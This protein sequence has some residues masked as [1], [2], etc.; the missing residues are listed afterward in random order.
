MSGPNKIPATAAGE[1]MRDRFGAV[2]CDLVISDERVFVLLADISVDRLEPARARF[3]D[4]VV[5]AGIME[6]TVMGAAAGIAIEGFIPVV[7][8]IVPFIVHRPY[9]QIRDGFLYQ[10]VGV[11]IISIG[12]S[13]DYAKEGYTH[14]GPDDVPALHALA[15]MRIALPGTPA[16]F[17]T[18]LRA[19]YD[20]GAATY[21]RLSTRAN[22]DDRAV[23]FGQLDVVREHV[24]RPV[25]V[26]VGP[27]LDPV[28]EAVDALDVSVA[29]CT[30]VAPFDHETLRRLAGST[31]RVVVVE[32][33][34][35]GTLVP[36]IVAAV[37]PLPVRVEAIGIPR[38]IPTAYGSPDDHDRL[39]GLT[40]VAITRRLESFLAD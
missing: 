14:H 37:A 22:Q 21:F 34:Y 12:A 8:S 23:R 6:Q 26:A 36:D 7:H 20:D 16:E 5:N 25:V 13:H 1:T 10:G 40:A 28:L 38:V 30:T 15:G 32:P 31:P 33:Y 18:L 29:Y 24:G 3:P 19:S 9:E 4:R 2:V 17:E 39:H 35:E 11:N 27:M